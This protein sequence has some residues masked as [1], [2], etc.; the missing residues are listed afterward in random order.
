MTI[1]RVDSSG[2]DDPMAIA[3]RDQ[4][5]LEKTQN[6][7]RE[8]VTKLEDFYRSGSTILAGFQNAKNQED[9]NLFLKQA[10][11]LTQK[12]GDDIVNQQPSNKIRISK[13]DIE[14]TIAIVNQAL[15]GE[16]DSDYALEEE[17]GKTVVNNCY[18]T[19]KAIVLEQ[20]A[21]GNN[22]PVSVTRGRNTEP[23]TTTNE[24]NQIDSTHEEIQPGNSSL[25]ASPE[26]ATQPE[27]SETDESLSEE[28]VDTLL[29]IKDM[30]NKIY[31]NP[32]DYDARE[33]IKIDLSSIEHSVKLDQD[34]SE[35]VAEIMKWTDVLA[36]K[37]DD[38][39]YRLDTKRLIE[40][41]IDDIIT[42]YSKK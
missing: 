18:E 23:Y 33:L 29:E 11:E 42:T 41:Y 1:D 5:E 4:F 26:A 24:N 37:N 22:I 20:R 9:K 2:Y 16:V 32:L 27:P 10:V 12:I 17:F 30:V 6:E 40:G 7:A 21:K 28:V 39:T 19:I 36:Q 34:D 31:T 3:D 8:L 35:R 14:D 38:W 13:Y 25:A 15:D